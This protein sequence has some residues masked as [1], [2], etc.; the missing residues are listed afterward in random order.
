MV[1]GGTFLNI[2]IKKIP[3]VLL[4]LY[5]SDKLYSMA[6]AIAITCQ[7]TCVC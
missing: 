2:Q 3:K 4:L 1:V 7:N 6:L 5:H